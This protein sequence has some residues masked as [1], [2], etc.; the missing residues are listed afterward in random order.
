MAVGSRI[1]ESDTG[2]D[3]LFSED[4]WGF[5]ENWNLSSRIQDN[6]KGLD[7]SPRYCRPEGPTTMPFPAENSGNTDDDSE[8]HQIYAIESELPE[9][10]VKGNAASLTISEEEKTKETSGQGQVGMNADAAKNV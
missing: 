7:Y 5:L 3:D 2:F 10:Q 6:T 4:W 1:W 9:I 8:K